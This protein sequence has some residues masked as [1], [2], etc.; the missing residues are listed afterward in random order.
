[1][2][3]LPTNPAH[4]GLGATASVEPEFTDESWYAAY[5][6]RHAADGIEGRLVSQ[7]SFDQS[8]DSWEVHPHGGELVICTA[9][10]LTLHQ[11]HPDGSTHT[12]ILHANDYAINPPGTWHTADVPPGT[13]ATAIFITP[14]E[15]TTHRRR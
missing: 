5:S 3:H 6:A 2:P 14:G 15:G 13:T 4:L 7:Y 11:E 8:W 12:I 10:T 1:M 9:G